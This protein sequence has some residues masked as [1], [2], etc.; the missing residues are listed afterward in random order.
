MRYQTGITIVMRM[1]CPC[2]GSAMFAH[3]ICVLYF[4]NFLYELCYRLSFVLTEE[5]FLKIEQGERLSSQ[6]RTSFWQW[7]Q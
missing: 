3:D 5:F 1:M 4:Q 2:M 6:R 7:L